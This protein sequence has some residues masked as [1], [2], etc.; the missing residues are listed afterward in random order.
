MATPY[1]AN[2]RGENPLPKVHIPSWFRIQS[3]SAYNDALLDLDLLTDNDGAAMYTNNAVSNSIL[4]L[5]G[6]NSINDTTADIYKDIIAIGDTPPRQGSIIAY[7]NNQETVLT[8]TN[9]AH[10]LYFEHAVL[11]SFNF[12]VKE[13][14]VIDRIEK[15]YRSLT[16][17]KNGG[18]LTT[19]TSPDTTYDMPDTSSYRMVINPTNESDA[20]VTSG[21]IL[22]LVEGGH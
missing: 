9:S 21:T 3:P 13:N 10:V 14:H 2:P 8:G 6:T 4:N 19:I 17:A 11:S 18:T 1:N 7:S 15:L 22:V 16:S 12:A 5:G 20:T